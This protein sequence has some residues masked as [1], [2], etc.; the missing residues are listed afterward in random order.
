VTY[1]L[2]NSAVLITIAGWLVSLAFMLF[3]GRR[4][5]SELLLGMFALW[6]SFPY[7]LMLW[8]SGRSYSWPSAVRTA[9]YTTM[10]VL[11]VVSAGIY[12]RVAFGPPQ[13]RRA[14]LFLL[15]PPASCVLVGIVMLAARVGGRS[16][17]R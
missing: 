2:Q 4:N 1:R 8:I 15:V 17:E 5:P 11:P 7:L 9:L 3:T 16:R 10:I 12:G 14:T 13:G 6:V